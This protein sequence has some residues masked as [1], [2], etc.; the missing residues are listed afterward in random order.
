MKISYSRKNRRLDIGERDT[1]YGTKEKEILE[2]E[3]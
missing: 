1:G 2:R 3:Q